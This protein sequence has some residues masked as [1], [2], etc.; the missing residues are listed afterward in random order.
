MK[1]QR[2]LGLTGHSVQ[3]AGDSDS[4][5]DFISKTRVEMLLFGLL[6]MANRYMNILHI[7]VTQICIG[8]IHIDH[9]HVSHTCYTHA[10]GSHMLH[11]RTTHYTHKCYIHCTLHTCYKHAH[12]YYTD[13]HRSHRKGNIGQIWYIMAWKAGSSISLLSCVSFVLCCQTQ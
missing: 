12:M 9:T 10:H 11:A 5:R 2:S 6:L 4:M 3:S 8:H 13:L 7:Y 1:T